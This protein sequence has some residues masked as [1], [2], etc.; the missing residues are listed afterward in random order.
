MNL[1]V[2]IFLLFLFLILGVLLMVFI[3]KPATI[4]E[5]EQIKIE[6]AT[7]SIKSL[8]RN[9]KFPKQIHF[10]DAVKIQNYF[11]KIDSLVVVY[12]SLTSYPLS[13]HLLVKANPWIIETV[14]NTDYYKMM[15]RDSF[16]YDQK[17][18]TVITS[19]D[20]LVIPDS[21][22]AV[23]LINRINKTHID[24]NIPEFK[25]RIYEDSIL[26]Y[27]FLIRVGQ[28]RK[29]Y[30]K[31]G[32]RITS[33][34]TK[35]GKGKIIGYSRYPDFYNPVNG[36]QFYLTHRDDRKTT[37]MPQIPWIITEIN[38]IRNGQLI[39]P[40]TNR[41]SLNKAYSNGCIGVTEGDAWVIYYHATV[42]TPI[43]IRYDLEVKD[44]LGNN[45]LLD[46]IYHL[47]KG[48]FQ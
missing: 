45:I 10:K 30:L 24:V 9:P 48:N 39:H 35:I 23:N 32:D 4:K 33:L 17:Q 44:S 27:T 6:N 20:S 15:E 25:L 43:S 12:D 14:A 40:T 16:V 3:M 7:D 19:L 47:K 46:D 13:E 8:Q 29:R 2:K 21:F 31:M 36:K 11:K 37:L 1:N 28:D 34:Q 42:G 26:L 18:L 5:T 22:V 41:K 38:G